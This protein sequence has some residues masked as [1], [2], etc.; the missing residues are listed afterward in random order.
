M[1]VAIH[2][3][4]EVDKSGRTAHALLPWM[5]E[6]SLD[7]AHSGL[8]EPT[9]RVQF[10]ELARRGRAKLPTMPI[11]ALSSVADLTTPEP[12]LGARDQEL[13]ARSLFRDCYAGYTARVV[14]IPVAGLVTPQCYTDMDYVDELK[15]ALPSSDD[16]DG[17][18]DF[19]FSEDELGTASVVNAG[20]GQLALV[21]IPRGQQPRIGKLRVERSS[22]RHNL[23]CSL[24]I[25]ARAHYVQIV[26]VQVAVPL[27]GGATITQRLVI[28]DGVHRL[29][30][31]LAGGRT[32]AYAVF[33]E[34]FPLQQVGAALGAFSLADAIGQPRPPQLADYLDRAVFEPVVVP[35][36]DCSFGVLVVPQVQMRPQEIDSD[37]TPSPKL[38]LK[39]SKLATLPQADAALD[40][41]SQ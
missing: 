40:R 28:V 7:A 23:T 17:L 9:D 36:L 10:K 14:R 4:G 24:T 41:P 13:E 22:D 34:Q 1:N 3:Q 27:A 38:S 11:S 31:L 30:A 29:L 25:E 35:A 8:L 2:T 6:G 18:F 39:G 15:T 20:Q 37:T 21:N 12:S 26:A 19:C 33:M 5:P 16:E 32:H